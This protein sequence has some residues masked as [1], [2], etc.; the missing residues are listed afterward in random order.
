MTDLDHDMRDMSTN[1]ARFL[2]ALT[3]AFTTTFAIEAQLASADSGAVPAKDYGDGCV[4]DPADRSVTIDSLR[5]WC[6]LEQQTAIF[7]DA[8]AGS[9]PRGVTNGWVV[10]PAA[11]HPIAPTFWTGKTFY[12]GS[13]GGYLMNQVTSAGF[14]GFRADVYTGPAITDGRPTWVL[15]YDSSPIP[16]IYDEIREI[17]PGLWFGYSWRRDTAPPT[18]LLTFALT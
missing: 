12:T 17:T 10:S 13:D 5:S 4:V 18:L 15:N 16:Q 6:S 3:A 11:I 7:S 8:S 9:V 2:M 14:E 1:R